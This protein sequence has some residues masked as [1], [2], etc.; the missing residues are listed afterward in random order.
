MSIKIAACCIVV[1]VG[2][3]GAQTASADKVDVQWKCAAP[4]P[5]HALPVG[6]AA[7][8]LFVIQQIKCTATRG[9]IAGVKNKNG[10][11]TEFAEATGSNSKG[12][13]IFVETL[14]NG[15]TITYAYTFTG[16]SKDKMLESGRNEW[17][18][19]SGTGKFKGITASGTCTAKGASDGSAVFDCM[20]TYTLPK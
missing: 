4:D 1:A 17:K 2:A 8:H 18:A 12:Q 14:A 9:E 13:G 15:D 10:A 6:A 16:L 3:L 20:G 19:T 5:V 11:G 7:D